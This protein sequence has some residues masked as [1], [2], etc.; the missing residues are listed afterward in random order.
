MGSSKVERLCTFA[1]LELKLLEGGW[2]AATLLLPERRE[3]SLDETRQL[4][5]LRL[6]AV[7]EVAINIPF[8]ARDASGGPSLPEGPLRPG[9]DESLFGRPADHP[10]GA[11]SAHDEPPLRVD[12]PRR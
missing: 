12:P 9:C 8:D 1:I 7:E 4:S 5:Q 3:P 6:A 10:E 2:R 11:F